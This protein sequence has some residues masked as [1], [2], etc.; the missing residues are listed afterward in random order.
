MRPPDDAGRIIRAWREQ[1]GLTQMA[2]AQAL[3]ITFSTVSRWENGHVR[4]SRLAWKAVEKLAADRG[5]PLPIEDRG[6]RSLLDHERTQ[7]GML[8]QVAAGVGAGG[9]DLH[10]LPPSVRED[11]LG[12]PGSDVPTA[13]RGGRPRVAHV[14]NLS[15]PFVGDLGLDAVD[16]GEESARLVLDVDVHHAQSDRRGSDVK[17]ASSPSRPARR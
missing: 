3:Y 16:T 10:S 15:A 14:Q 8:H 6:D 4:P 7:F 17:P 11:R 9:N 1:I 5:G 2:L 12:Q 13:E